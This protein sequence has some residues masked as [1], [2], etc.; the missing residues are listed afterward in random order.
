M[1]WFYSLILLIY[2][3]AC[4]NNV[5][6]KKETNKQPNILWIVCED[7]S[8]TLSFYGDSIAKTPNLDALAKESMVYN[9]AFA[10]VGVC[11]PTRSAII[12]GMYPTSIGTM[13]MR[14]G[15]DVQSWGNRTYKNR[16][17]SDILDIENNPIQQYSAVVPED[18]K[19]FTEYLRAQGYYCTNNAK[20]DYQFA[21]PITSWD[22]N[23]NNAHWRNTPKGKPFFSVFNINDT[24]ESQLWK[25]NKLPLTVNPK[26]VKV[27][28]YLPDTEATRLTIAR[29][30][31]NVEIMD[32]KVGDIIRQ[33]KKDGLYNNTIVFFYSDHGGPL[34]RQKR[35][36]Y[37]SGLKVPFMVKGIQTKSGYTNRMISFVDLA[38]TVL[39]LAGLKSPKYMEGKAFLGKYKTKE[40]AYVYGTSDRFDEFTDRIRAVRSS[41]FLYLKNYHPNLTKYKDVGYRKQVPMMLPF[42]ELE[43]ENKLNDVQQSWFETKTTEELYDVENDPHNLYNLA[44]NTAYASEL[45]KMRTALDDF[46]KNRKDYGAQL[47]SELI[48]SMWPNFIQPQT[49]KVEIII[50]KEQ[51]QLNCKTSGASVAYM[52]SDVEITAVHFDLPWRLYTKPFNVKKGQYIYAIAQRIGYKESEVFKQKL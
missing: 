18:V 29:H 16:Q 6:S 21:A 36:I 39:S 4:S 10:P 24:H 28:P 12:T 25:K 9:N 45:K 32:K 19:C 2:C 17:E 35:E 51:V 15:M 7:I 48:E 38:P 34:P 31:S 43:K 40:R 52:V 50:A 30:Y 23:N 41:K 46:Q 5:N 42:L 13:H 26:D 27:P 47:E 33:L 44:S 3:T 14:T 1:K 8:P 20:T 49:E 37:D 22:E 11:A